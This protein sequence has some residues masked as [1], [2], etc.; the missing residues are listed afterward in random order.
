MILHCAE[1][2]PS[3]VKKELRRLYAAKRDIL[4]ADERRT[5][6]LEIIRRLCGL[7][8]IAEAPV[9]FIY[10]SFRSEVETRDCITT[11]LAQGK[12]VAVPLIDPVAKRMLPIRI[13][14]LSALVPGPLGILQPPDCVSEIRAQ[15]IDAVIVPGLAFTASGIRLGYGGGFYDAF[16]RAHRIPAYGLAFECQLCDDI[17]FI[18][19]RDMR[20]DYI[21]TEN[22]CINCKSDPP[23]T[24]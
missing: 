10:V 2:P 7:P 14:T 18:P 21:V 3:D 4:L 17:P 24:S 16:L 19:G 22:R 8:R 20:V 15:A 11:L 9:I 13:E 1:Y 12:I 23:V 5:K 6:S